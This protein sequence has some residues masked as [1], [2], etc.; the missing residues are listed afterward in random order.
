MKKE[1][2]EN[3]GL[4]MEKV[5]SLAKRR[6]FVYP[7]S[8]IYGGLA[9]AWDFGPLGVELKNNIKKSWWNFF[10][11]QRDDIY[12][13]DAAIL[14]N[15]KTWSA[16]GHLSGFSDALIEC[17]NCHERF[18]ADAVQKDKKGNNLCPSCG[19]KEF[20]EPRQFNLMLQTFLGP[21][22][23]EAHLVYFRPETAQAMFVDFK[24]ILDTMSPKIPFGI[25][26]IGKAFRNE[27]TPGNFIFRTREFEQMEIEY[28]V[29]PA[30]WQDQFE[31][32]LGELKKWMNAIGLD[33]SKISYHEV[34]NH[35]R[36]HYSARTID[37]E[38][39]FP[40][41]KKELYGLAYR[42]DFD[43]R[44]HQAA[45]GQNLE[46]F[47]PK[48]GEKFLP[49]VIEPSLGVE[50]TV[51]ALLVSAYREEKVALL[52]E[53]A[54]RGEKNETR[55]YLDLNPQMAPFKA[56]VFPLLANK[57]DLLKKARD[58]YHSIKEAGI[59]PADFDDNGNIGKRYRRQDEV[60]TPY[61]FT[62]D[63]QTLEDDT[64]TVRDRNTMKQERI[65]AEKV[66]DFLK[67]KLK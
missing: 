45:S 47:E 64:V 58:V 63:F 39:D 13:L 17:K 54:S 62:V 5:L 25:A 55:I 40:F 46:Y 23:D 21:A 66:P 44:S 60:G 34:P 43:L 67:E 4:P 15:P 53:D 10:V 26:Q 7:S 22:Q 12:G 24:Q 18:R 8:E 6:G 52:R 30:A 20:T 37:I 59:L 57:P 61:C 3:D 29:K 14:M 31:Y 28:F 33:E 36:A 42:G 65:K 16:S 49:H 2:K 32:W 1:K 51:L 48:T 56:A 38:F 50:R 35:E 27:V 41:G 9:N 11:H 19:Q